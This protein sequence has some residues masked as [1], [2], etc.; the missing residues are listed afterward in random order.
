MVT[1]L[2]DK[3]HARLILPQ[4]KLLEKMRSHVACRMLS[5]LIENACGYCGQSTCYSIFK[6]TRFVKKTDT[7]YYKVQSN[8]PY[9]VFHSKT[10]RNFS[11]RNKCT[12]HLLVCPATACE[13]PVWKYNLPAHYRSAHPN[14]VIPTEL[15]TSFKEKESVMMALDLKILA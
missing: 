14:L 7:Q 13:I 5:G 3:N 11:T 10:P 12:N 15:T 1:Y 8:C 9:F 6:K 2:N 4:E